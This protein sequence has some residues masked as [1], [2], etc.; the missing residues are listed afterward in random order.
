MLPRRAL[1]CTLALVVLAALATAP[2]MAEPGK[3]DR[4]GHGQQ[5]ER[6]GGQDGGRD[7]GSERRQEHG[8]D[9]GKQSGQRQDHG[10]NRG[11]SSGQRQNFSNS[12]GNGA[13]QRPSLSPREAAERA[14]SQYGGQVLKVS[15]EGNGYRVRLLQDDGRV[16]SV[17][18]GN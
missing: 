18:V 11:N 15:P 17:P 5:Q 1:T 10:S 2:A 6:R 4:S 9:R 12:R 16:V 7:K 8:D 13:E 3:K 14:R